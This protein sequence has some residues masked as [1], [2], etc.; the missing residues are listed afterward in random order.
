MPCFVL[1]NFCELNNESVSDDQLRRTI[2]TDRD[3]QPDTARNRYMTDRNKAEGKRLKTVLTK[4]FDPYLFVFVIY[5][6]KE[7]HFLKMNKKVG[8]LLQKVQIQEE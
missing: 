2:N 5:I 8:M 3:F 1:H 4:Y 6:K 7:K